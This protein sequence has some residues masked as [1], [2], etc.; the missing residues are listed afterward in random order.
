MYQ[1]FSVKYFWNAA[2]HPCGQRETFILK[3]SLILSEGILK[4]YLNYFKSLKNV[5]LHKCYNE[6]KMNEI[7]TNYNI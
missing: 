7:H 2:L 5:L 3:Y 4:L 6:S 1:W